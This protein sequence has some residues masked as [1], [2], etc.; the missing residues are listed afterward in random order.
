LMRV[1]VM[2]GQYLDVL[3]ENAAATQDYNRICRQS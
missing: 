1:E 2:A 3:E